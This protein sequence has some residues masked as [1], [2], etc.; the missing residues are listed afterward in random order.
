MDK[1]RCV[2]SSLEFVE[3]QGWIIKFFH[4]VTLGVCVGSSVWIS[5]L[6]FT[7]AGLRSETNLGIA[8]KFRTKPVLLLL[9]KM[10]S[11]A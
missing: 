2:C 7:T 1:G 5:F 4:C 3:A 10:S 11:T 6:S 8:L 9:W